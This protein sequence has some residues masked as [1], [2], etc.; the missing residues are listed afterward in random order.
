MNSDFLSSS[1]QLKAPLHC[2]TMSPLI[3]KL[4]RSLDYL[5][6]LFLY[7]CRIFHKRNEM[8]QLTISTQIKTWDF[9][10]NSNITNHIQKYIS[11][12]FWNL[13]KPANSSYPAK[14]GKPPIIYQLIIQH[15][16]IELPPTH[17]ISFY[18]W[19]NP[20]GTPESLDQGTQNEQD[21]ERRDM[22]RISRTHF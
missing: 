5:L 22:I 14:R 10:Q 1:H 20:Q 8:K 4:N 9:T 19:R 11:R 16:T 7:I 12:V 18:D 6:P 13:K 3:Y 15:N 17:G 2:P 21:L